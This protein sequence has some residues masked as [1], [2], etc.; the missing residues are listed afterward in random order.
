MARSA[1]MVIPSVRG[2]VSDIS[3]RSSDRER[4]L[5]NQD[6]VEDVSARDSPGDGSD[7]A[8][9]YPNSV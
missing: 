2:S 3:C 1:L 4:H 5:A 9:V 6:P 7:W 8:T